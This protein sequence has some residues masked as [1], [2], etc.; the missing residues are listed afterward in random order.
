MLTGVNVA[1]LISL[2]LALYGWSFDQIVLLPAIV[3]VA[4]WFNEPEFDRRKL[5]IISLIVI[6]IVL[7]GMKLWGVGDFWYMWVPLALGVLY[8]A[9]YAIRRAK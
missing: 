2:P 6:Y 5:Y 1:L 7:L 8:A 4:F 9:G 3:Q